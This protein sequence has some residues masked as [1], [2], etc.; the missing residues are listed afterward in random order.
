DRAGDIA[1][2]AINFETAVA[3]AYAAPGPVFAPPREIDLSIGNPIGPIS[4]K[5]FPSTVST[6]GSTPMLEAQQPDLARV[7]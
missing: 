6:Q 4:D 1:N 2:Y 3:A 7:I 5:A